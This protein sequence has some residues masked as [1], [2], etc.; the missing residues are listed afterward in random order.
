[1]ILTA[2]QEQG[3]KIAVERYKNHEPYTVIAGYAGVGKSTLIRF[4]IA[5]LD[6]D[7]DLKLPRFCGTRV[8]TMP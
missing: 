6:I 2:K 7:P 3:L 8:A 1:M 5:A 4:I